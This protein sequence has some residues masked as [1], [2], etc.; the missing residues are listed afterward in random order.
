[1]KK[2]RESE[3]HFML[4]QNSHL[5]RMDRRKRNQRCRVK[6][7]DGTQVTEVR[8]KPNTSGSCVKR[9]GTWSL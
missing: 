5:G 4:P 8:I 3:K 7:R 9:I 2:P 6:N 1:M